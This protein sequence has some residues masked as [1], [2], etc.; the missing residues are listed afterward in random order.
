MRN[1]REEKIIPL[2]KANYN[3]HSNR[4]LKTANIEG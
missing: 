4:S 1:Y 2:G 3:N